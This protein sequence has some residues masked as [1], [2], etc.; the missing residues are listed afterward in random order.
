MHWTLE[1]WIRTLLDCKLQ[2][3][4]FH[5]ITFWIGAQDISLQ[6]ILMQC[7]SAV[8]GSLSVHLGGDKRRGG[9]ENLKIW[10]T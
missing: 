3:M 8:Q 9:S 10:L 6:C 2:N 5:C 1:H 4:E 7:K